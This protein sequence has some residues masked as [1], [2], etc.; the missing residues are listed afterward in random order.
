MHENLLKSIEIAKQN[1][2]WTFLDAIE[3]LEIP[4]DL[5]L[6]FSKNRGTLEY[7]ESLS[8]SAKKSILYWV[9]SAKRE[10]TR[11]KRIL[12]IVENALQ[13]NKFHRF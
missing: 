4:N 6:E 11:Q 13:K 8:K 1:G 10:Q 3:N 12:E 9:I 7:F 5:L 2:S